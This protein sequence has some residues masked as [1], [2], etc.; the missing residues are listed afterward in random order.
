ML[1]NIGQNG[2]VARPRAG[3]LH[4]VSLVLI[5][6]TIFLFQL[7]KPPLWD[8]DEPRNAGCAAEMLVANEWIVPT[9]NGELR[10]H[11]PVLLYWLVMGSYG[12]FGINEFAARLPSALLGIGSVLLTYDIGRRTFGSRSGFWAGLILATT[13]MFGVASRAVTPD[14]LLI[15][16][17]T[18]AIA[19]FVRGTFP[20]SNSTPMVS[21]PKSPWLVVGMYSAMGLGVLAKGPV[22]FVLPTAVIGMYL[23]IIRLPDREKV[24]N[25]LRSKLVA[26]LRP[27]APKHFLA[28]FCVMRPVAAIA[29]AGAVALP[30]YWMVSFETDGVWTREFLWEHNVN[31]A[32]TSMEGHSG[33]P[34]L[35]YLAAIMVGF[36]PWTVFAI[37]TGLFAAKCLQGRGLREH[38]LRM[39]PGTILMLSWIGVYVVLFS[40]AST[41]LPSYVTPCYPA[42]ALLVG[43]LFERWQTTDQTVTSMLQAGW[44]KFALAN[45]IVVGAAITIAIPIAAR[46]WLPGSEWLGVV[47]LAPLLAGLL[48]WRLLRRNR[49]FQATACL[50]G[51][52]VAFC[53]LLLAVLPTELGRHRDY[54]ELFKLTSQN[55]GPIASFGHLEPSWVFYG[56]R[57]IR[58]FRASEAAQLQH[59]LRDQPDAVVLTTGQQLSKLKNSERALAHAPVLHRT[60]Y[61]LR[62]L[63]LLVIQSPG[64]NDGH[65]ETHERHGSGDLRTASR[66]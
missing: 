23:L 16:C 44:G 33:P 40:L 58:E 29:I 24:D 26:I 62:D 37:P 53:T 18:L 36:F 41:K 4:T 64:L 5:A 21:F 2:S 30:W 31:R 27:W 50:G 17:S 32:A 48:G 65:T 56:G 43:T 60:K 13:I 61:F 34:I 8:R 22:G 25:T 35:F 46:I 49:H 12:L 63:D 1:S 20:H 51:G 45:L 52:A 7:G 54:S 28:T 55:S 11:K 59:F 57:Q 14:A 38:E 6:G 66:P 9:F 10:T 19:L 42:I 39:R 15:F 47:G 3:L